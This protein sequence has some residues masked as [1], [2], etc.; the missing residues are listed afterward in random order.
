[1]KWVQ[2]MNNIYNR[3]AEVVYNDWIY[4]CYPATQEIATVN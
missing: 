1:M 3:T 2:A 4:N